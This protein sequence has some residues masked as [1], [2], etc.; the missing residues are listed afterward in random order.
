M[1]ELKKRLWRAD[2]IIFLVFGICV[3]F[4]LIHPVGLPI[5]VSSMTREFFDYI[6][7]LPAGSL[8]MF[9]GEYDLGAA[10]N[11]MWFI[12]MWNHFARNKIKC[13]AMHVGTMVATAEKDLLDKMDLWNRPGYVYGEDWV[14]LGYIPG[15]ETAVAALH[16]DFQ[17]IALVDYE[18]TPASE[19]PLLQG[20]Q[21]YRDFDLAIAS[22]WDY[23]IFA[24]QWPTTPETPTICMVDTYV[25]AS[26]LPFYPDTFEAMMNGIKGAAEYE[27]LLGIPGRAIASSDALT[28]TT[29]VM[30]G[31]LVA[32]QVSVYMVRQKVVR[33]EAA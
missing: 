25:W 30:V 21:D 11:H 6:D 13:V 5:E 9:L 32:A 17:S 3:F 28:L 18:G 24:R 1:A 10:G 16:E 12:D 26:A 31:A 14:F 2:R 7:D 20:I 15:G 4:P 19:L 23:T 22:S 29:L 27:I 8:V 33:K